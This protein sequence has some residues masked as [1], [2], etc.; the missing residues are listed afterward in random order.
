MRNGTAIASLAAGLLLAS[1][2]GIGEAQDESTTPTLHNHAD[3]GGT[4]Q[5]PVPVGY[6]GQL[7][8]WNHG[9]DVARQA[10]WSSSRPSVVRVDNNGFIRALSA[11]TA[12]IRA[13][14]NGAV[15]RPPLVIQVTGSSTGV[16]RRSGRGNTVLNVPESVVLVRIT[17]RFTGGGQN[18]IVKC[19]PNANSGL[20]VNEILGTRWDSTTYDGTHSARGRYGPR[21]N[22]PCRQFHIQDSN[23]VSWEFSQTTARSM[24]YKQATRG[25]LEADE[26]AV[27]EN[28]ERAASKRER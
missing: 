23:G 12:S 11:G 9:R 15:S 16:W 4:V 17:A 26:Q 24:T 25:S 27:R 7:K 13:T 6:S 3:S 21:R 20:M 1:L 18:F 5:V 19:G 10:S 14:Y 22:L 28:I 8:L 2:L